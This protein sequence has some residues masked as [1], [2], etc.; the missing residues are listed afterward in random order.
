MMTVDRMRLIETTYQA[1]IRHNQERPPS[2][3]CL[4]GYTVP[5]G[6][7]FSAHVAADIIDALLPQLTTEQ[8]RDE[9]LN[10]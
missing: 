1:L 7:R 10:A 4:C 2:G 9:A 6:Y 8:D 3:E 5:L